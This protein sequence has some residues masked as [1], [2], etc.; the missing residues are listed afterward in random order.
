MAHPLEEDLASVTRALR[1]NS[2]AM[3]IEWARAISE[4]HTWTNQQYRDFIEAFQVSSA[5]LLRLLERKR[6]LEQEIRASKAP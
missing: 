4:G 3:R 5:D 2:D 6:H 1:D